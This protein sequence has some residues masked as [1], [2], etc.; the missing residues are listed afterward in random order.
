MA[1]DDDAATYNGEDYVESFLDA[2]RFG[3]FQVVHDLYFKDSNK[4]LL[5][6]RDEFRNTPLHLAAGNGQLEVA[7]F[8]VN[9]GAE[10]NAQN[11]AGNTPLHWAALLGE[12]EVVQF[13]IAQGADP[14]VENEFH[15]TPLD[16]A[17]DKGHLSVVR[18]LEK[19]LETHGKTDTS[20]LDEQT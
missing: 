1:T 18:T 10:L 9:K 2:A 12:L 19:L 20:W 11:D 14:C 7:K 4:L 5:N 15:R 8:L 6:A 13:L 16:E 3:D 17:V